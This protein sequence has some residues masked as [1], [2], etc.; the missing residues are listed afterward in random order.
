MVAIS[1]AGSGSSSSAQ[2]V[3]ARYQQKLSAGRAARVQSADATADPSSPDFDPAAAATDPSSP[4]YDPT[5][6]ATDP[7]S[8]GYDP[9]AAAGGT[10]AV[11]GGTTANG[12]TL[13]VTV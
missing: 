7:S 13:D 10:A 6:A 9:A 12:G 1:P 8:P 3:I 5:L 2:D 11:A 4:Y